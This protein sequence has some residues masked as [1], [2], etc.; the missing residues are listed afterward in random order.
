MTRNK[1]GFIFYKNSIYESFC[2]YFFS[3]KCRKIPKRYRLIIL[4]LIVGFSLFLTLINPVASSKYTIYFY[5]PETNI[6]NF[7]SLKIEFDTYLS[8]F[9]PYEFQPFSDKDTFE[10]FIAQKRDC[11]FLISSWHFR[12]LKEEYQMEPVLVGV[13]NG[14][15]TQK[16]ILLA[17]ENIQTLDL[18]KGGKVASAGNENYTKN[19][20]IQILGE[21][22]R[23]VADSMRVLTVPK[24]IDALMAV[25]FGMA[26]SALA[27]ESS[28]D[29]LSS[30]N[31]NQ[32]KMLK[33]LT[34]SKEILLPIVAIPQKCD[35]DV[36]ELV[37]IIEK[38]G[39]ISEGK[40]KLKMLGLDG[41]KR[42][43]ES[44]MKRF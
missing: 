25:G 14:K 19:I 6:N 12:N 26:N 36:E 44:E 11:A 18:L 32:Y 9:G 34:T 35:K 5:N 1:T 41:W 3:Q 24:D 22:K 39:K 7:A 29:K 33:P 42:W 4:C 16:K 28:L 10:K 17:K 31:P 21:K 13:L 27:A 8:S 37:T 2:N 38:M 15:F 23:E 30:I 43:D 40:K 20:L